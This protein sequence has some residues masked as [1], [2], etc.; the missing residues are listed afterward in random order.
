VAT[1]SSDASTAL[2]NRASLALKWALPPVAI[3]LAARVSRAGAE[4]GGVPPM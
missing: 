4:R 2:E 3:G 1:R